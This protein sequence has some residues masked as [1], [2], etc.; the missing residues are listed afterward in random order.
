[1]ELSGYR[2]IY[3]SIVFFP[4]G[5]LLG[6]AFTKRRWR[7]FA[8]AG[9]LA[10]EGLLAPFVLQ[11]ALMDSSGGSFSNVNFGFSAGM[12]ALGFLWAKSDGASEASE[13]VVPR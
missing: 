10:L 4:A 11:W 2:D 9:L 12:I 5:A 1:M 13:A 6:I 7:W 3:Y 8:L